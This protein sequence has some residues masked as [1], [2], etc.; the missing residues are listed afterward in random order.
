MSITTTTDLTS[1]T[2]SSG[3]ADAVSTRAIP[4]TRRRRGRRL[5]LAAI[6]AAVVAAA[7]L[8]VLATPSTSEAASG[9][10]ACFKTR[11]GMIVGPV[12]T[13][14]ELYTNSGW[15]RVASS[16][17][18]A[19]NGCVSFTMTGSYRNYYSRIRMT[20]Y[21]STGDYFHATSP[22]MA[23]PGNLSVNLGTAN[24]SCI[25]FCYGV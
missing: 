17:T 22:L 21:A 13:N 2:D 7:T 4:T 8:G 23:L 19:F 6:A 12:N 5:P 10:S 9:V 15:V 16:P 11:T 14:L 18:S 3:S 25:G 20:G 1:Q 24:V